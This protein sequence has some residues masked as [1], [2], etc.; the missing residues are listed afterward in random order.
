L[1]GREERGREVGSVLVRIDEKTYFKLL[2]ASQK[3]KKTMKD[4]LSEAVERYL[5]ELDV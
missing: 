4:I 2:E 5:G 1:E 3:L